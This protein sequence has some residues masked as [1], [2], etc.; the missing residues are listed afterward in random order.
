MSSAVTPINIDTS[1][2][3]KQLTLC[4]HTTHKDLKKCE[5]KLFCAHLHIYLLEQIHGLPN[6]LQFLLSFSLVVFVSS[7]RIDVAIKYQLNFKSCLISDNKL[8]SFYVTI[9][10]VW[11]FM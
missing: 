7:E 8:V 4:I 10:K 2:N 9:I 5:H 11:Y 6:L 1:K 3:G